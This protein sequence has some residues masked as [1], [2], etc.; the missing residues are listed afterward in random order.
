MMVASF[1]IGRAELAMVICLCYSALLRVGESL[2]LTF[3]DVFFSG[4]SLVLCLARTKRGMEQKV[5]VNQYN[6][7][8]L[9][10]SISGVGHS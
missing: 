6:S 8:N 2:Q 4:G 5:G 10:V 7:G 9:D 1:A 3:K